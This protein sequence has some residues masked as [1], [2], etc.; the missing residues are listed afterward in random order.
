[1]KNKKV[2]VVIPWRAQEK[3]LL[4][5]G[6]LREWYTSNFPDIEIVVGKSDTPVFSPAQAKNA[7]F[8]EA[9]AKGADIVIFHDADS[10]VSVDSL[11]KAIE[12]SII[13]NAITV[14]YTVV[15]QHTTEQETLD[16]FTRGEPRTYSDLYYSPTIDSFGKLSA[17]Y[18]C[19]GCNV[20]P[21]EIF[22]DIGGFDE[23]LLNWGPED[24]LFHKTYIEK[25]NNSFIYI[26]GILHSTYNYPGNRVLLDVH[27]K[28][29]ESIREFVASYTLPKNNIF[30]FWAGINAQ[31]YMPDNRKKCYYSLVKNSGCRITLVTAQ[32]LYLYEVPEFPVHE[33]YPYLTNTHKSDYARS[34][35]MHHY[36]GGYSDIKNCAFDWNPYFDELEASDKDFASYA[37]T[38]PYDL[39]YTPAASV[40]SQLGGNGLFI[41]KKY[42]LTSTLVYNAVQ[43]KLDSVLDQLKLYPGTNH[44]RTLLKD[45]VA[46]KESK[47]P[48]LWA[49]VQG[50]IFHKVQYENL[51][52]SLLNMP[53]VDM[54]NYL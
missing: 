1:M 23:T 12:A 24:Q 19:G 31:D 15:T 33:A 8:K 38:S 53:Y 41:F 46:F 29:R 11:K 27:A 40:Y 6:K 34:Y 39:G 28:V 22:E 14:P 4:A 16:F 51:G 7:G 48:L 21:V 52:R 47:Y 44:S 30:V 5:F 3:R 26:P 35:L 36:G 10:F 25:Y 13:R 17:I 37:E 9:V 54:N 2:V 18:P 42:S 20:V 50:T 49:D 45:P 43:E 32:D